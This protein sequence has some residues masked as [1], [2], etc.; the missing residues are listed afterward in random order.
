[1]LEITEVS[2]AGWRIVSAKGRAGVQETE[3]LEKALEAAA[4]TGEKVALDLSA[5]EY[6]SSAGLRSL[7]SGARAAQTHQVEFVVCSPVPG[8]RK[9]FEISG[10]GSLVKIQEGLPC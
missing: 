4:A 7:L 10:I 9:V 3:T 8:V 6:I 5:L 2:R 1:M